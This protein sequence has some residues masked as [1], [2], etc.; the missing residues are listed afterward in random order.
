[1][2]VDDQEGWIP[3][4]GYHAYGQVYW[5]NW[6]QVQD[7]QSADVWY[8]ALPA[9]LSVKPASDYALPSAKLPFYERLSFFHCPSAPLPRVAASSGYPI[10]LFSM[11]MNSQLIQAPNNLTIRFD[12]IRHSSKTPLFLD[13]LLEDESRVVPQQDRTNLGQPSAYANRFAGRRHGRFGNIVF[14]DGHAESLLGEKVVETRGLNAG[15]SI[16]PPVNV[17]W[18]P[19]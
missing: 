4:E 8:N 15:W 17:F 16:V 13:N 6:A 3:R 19:D 9:Y 10:A 12:A 7:P 2:Y 5:N 18:D 11:A 14:D 1:M